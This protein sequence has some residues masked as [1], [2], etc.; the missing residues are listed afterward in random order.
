MHAKLVRSGAH[1]VDAAHR[2]GWRLSSRGV[3]DEVLAN[4]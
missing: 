1:T 3:L 2:F 4:A